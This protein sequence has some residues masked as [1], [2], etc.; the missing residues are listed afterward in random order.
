MEFV[1]C[2][3]LLAYGF[4]SLL[5]DPLVGPNHAS[6]N[7][8]YISLSKLSV[9]LSTQ[10]RSSRNTAGALLSRFICDARGQDGLKKSEVGHGVGETE[11]MKW[12]ISAL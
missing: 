6:L 12:N 1:W 9:R 2:T 5:A 3:Q 11:D 7:D 10:E 8:F 4:G